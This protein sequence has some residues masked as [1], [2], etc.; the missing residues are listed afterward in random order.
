MLST[1]GTPDRPTNSRN[2]LRVVL[3]RNLAL[4]R[5]RQEIVEEEKPTEGGLSVQSLGAFPKHI[6]TIQPPI[7]AARRSSPA[8]EPADTNNRRFVARDLRWC[9]VKEC[10]ERKFKYALT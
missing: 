6:N 7:V 10:L 5:V 8:S 3:H 9:R 2:S 4:D 1:D